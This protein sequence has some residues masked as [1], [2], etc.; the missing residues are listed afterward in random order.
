MREIWLRPNRR[1]IL[2]GCI[3]PLVL[4]AVGAWL[5]FGIGESASHF[6][7]WLGFFLL[8]AGLAMI[9]TMLS[10]LRHPRIA[11]RDGMVLFYVRIGPPIAVP[12]E[13]VESFFFGQGPAHL[14]AVSKQ[15]QSVN[16]IARLSQRH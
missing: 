4:A 1:A 7:R 16:L 13:I 3:P 9:S 12:V 15:P 8:V 10:Q 6:W 5:V 11:F 14:P 2:F